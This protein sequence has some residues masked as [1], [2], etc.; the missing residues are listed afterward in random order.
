MRDPVAQRLVHRVLQGRGAG[1][2]RHDLGAEQLHAEHVRL[3]PL[4]V[5]RA[6]VDDAGQVEQRA[7]G[8]GGDAVLAG[9]GL[10]D[11][12]ALA[13][14]ARQQDLAEHVVDLVRAGMVQLVAF[15][16]ELGAAEMPGQP[17]G[18]IE[19]A[20][21]P[22]IMVEVIG[23]L[24]VEVRVVPGRVVG[25]L[26]RQDQRHQRLGDIAPAIDAEMAA[27]VRPAAI[28]V[29]C[30]HHFLAARC[31]TE[32]RRHGELL[33]SCLRVFVLIKAAGDGQEFADLLR[34][35]VAGAALDAGGH[36]DRASR[37]KS[38]PPRA[39]ARRSARPTAS[40]AGATRARRSAASRT[41]D[42]CRPAARRRGA[43]ASRRTAA[44]RRSLRSARRPSTSSAAAI[45][46]AFMTGRPKRALTSATRSGLSLPWNCRMSS[47]AAASAAAIAAS[48]ASTNRPTR[49]TAG[50]HLGA[51]RGGAR[52][53]SRRAGSAGR[54]QSRDTPRR[55]RP[56]R[57][58]PPRSTTRRS[59][60]RRSCARYGPSPATGEGSRE[61]LHSC[62]P[63][64]RPVRNC[65]RTRRRT[66]RLSARTTIG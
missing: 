17:L 36:I 63:T 18:E 45:A 44:D 61:A 15:E 34:V 41:R 3:L 58:P 28:G 24:G 5:G 62:D 42:R 47:G 9:A 26:D 55:P 46:I 29:R 22:D 66:R 16:I 21:P 11:D 7:G 35:L 25:L 59:W 39:A 2:H 48:S 6:H 10:G 51:Q 60:R 53:R 12:A 65:H 27:R 37:R 40:T 20:R 52:R 30:L 13:H 23:Q 31:T 54:R 43:A 14:A 1:M 64:S 33:L 57:Q 38:A 56:R 8:R 19:R 49:R 32:T 4:D 50:R